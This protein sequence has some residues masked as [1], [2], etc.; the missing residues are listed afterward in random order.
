MPRFTSSLVFQKIP[1][2]DSHLHVPFD[3]APTAAVTSPAVHQASDVSQSFPKGTIAA[4]ALAGILAFVLIS[5]ALFYFFV[6][7]PRQR[8]LRRERREGRQRQ[9]QEVTERDGG[10]PA[11]RLGS[12]VVDIGPEPV[13]LHD[14]KNGS[15]NGQ[16]R[17]GSGL[18]RGWI[19]VEIDSKRRDSPRNTGFTKWKKDIESGFGMES[20]KGFGLAFRSPDS[21]S[22]R[23]GH[24]GSPSKNDPYEYHEHNGRESGTDED[25]DGGED[26]KSPGLPQLTSLEVP[27]KGDKKGKSRSTAAPAKPKA[28]TKSVRSTSSWTP[29]FTVDL[30]RFKSRSSSGSP[31]Y[32]HSRS[33]QTEPLA[34][35]SNAAATTDRPGG[36]ATP[37]SVPHSPHETSLASSLS[38]FSYFSF[39]SARSQAQQ[40]HRQGS[41]GGSSGLQAASL[42]APNSNSNSNS[43]PSKPPSP[44]APQ[45]VLKSSLRPSA[46]ADAKQGKSAKTAGHPAREGSTITS[47]TTSSLSPPNSVPRSA[48]SSIPLT[49]GSGSPKSEVSKIQIPEAL[50]E[51]SVLPAASLSRLDRPHESR[52]TTSPIHPYAAVAADVRGDEEGHGQSQG[53]YHHARAGSTGPLL[54]GQE[55]NEDENMRYPPYAPGIP[56]L[57]SVTN[58]PGDTAASAPGLSGDNL[59]PRT[60]TAGAIL[61]GLASGSSAEGTTGHGPLSPSSVAPI[62]TS[63]PA[64]AP[65][66]SPITTVGG[67]TIRRLPNP[68]VVIPTNAPP[69]PTVLSA[70]SPTATSAR[71]SVLRPPLPRPPTATSV[72]VTS[73]SGPSRANLPAVP[74]EPTTAVSESSRPVSGTD[75]TS[76]PGYLSLAESSPFSIPWRT[77]AE[78]QRISTA[79]TAAVPGPSSNSGATTVGLPP[80]QRYPPSAPVARTVSLSLP[81]R[82]V[83][84]QRLSSAEATTTPSAST[85]QQRPST[86]P[87]APPAS[88][89][90]ISPAKPHT[91]VK[92]SFRLTPLSPAALQKKSPN[93]RHKPR[94]SDE[95]AGADSSFLDFGGGRG[96]IRGSLGSGSATSGSASGFS[97]A[98]STASGSTAYER[99][100]EAAAANHPDRNRH[101]AFT[102]VREVPP[103]VPPL[104]AELLSATAPQLA[105]VSAS[106][107][108]ESDDASLFR[109]LK[110]R[111][112]ATTGS[113]SASGAPSESHPTPRGQ[114]TTQTELH[115]TPEPASSDSGYTTSRP[116][117]SISPPTIPSSNSSSANASQSSDLHVH[118][119]LSI[120]TVVSSNLGQHDT[121]GMSFAGSSRP[122]QSRGPGSA[123][124][125]FDNT[126][127]V[128]RPHRAS[129]STSTTNFTTISND[130]PGPSPTESLPISDIRFGRSSS[131]YGVDEGIN[132]DWGSG[133]SSNWFMMTGPGAGN[134]GGPVTSSTEGLAPAGIGARS[135]TSPSPVGGIRTQRPPLPFPSLGSSQS[136]VGSSSSSQIQYRH[137]SESSMN[138]PTRG[139]TAAT[140]GLTTPSYIVQRVLRPSGSGVL[141][142]GLATATQAGQTGSGI[143]VQQQ[144][145]PRTDR[146][147][148]Q[149]GR[150]RSSS[151]TF[152]ALLRGGNKDKEP[153]T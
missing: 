124:S 39:I 99:E 139:E 130:G 123:P 7:K 9:K 111:W 148:Q 46:N 64:S 145:E 28:K 52:R 20:L 98:A 131:D 42:H 146:P 88:S 153:Q 35:A 17:Q 96:H 70:V 121:L 149:H 43:Q 68:P 11:T 87:T 115:P 97:R 21:S 74:P 75:S 92:S 104:P 29:S 31:R 18:D 80:Y 77:L 34:G 4:L 48:V 37:G 144:Q 134:I 119:H 8:R 13:V 127:L 100:R 86:A 90:D 117:L 109:G 135:P 38:T 65:G 116:N 114:D 138:P 142:P 106:G 10:V 101:S 57:A 105:P 113:G 69:P 108:S 25:D 12:V 71:M 112:S 85:T 23:P 91:P 45:A 60:V 102:G 53:R 141:S 30:S 50:I 15:S 62:A 5:I 6:W 83:I 76:L 14:L 143:F 151:S 59:S 36:R 122:S 132:S 67:K 32:I 84:S 103:P 120:S 110:S 54:S 73:I 55:G 44:S 19:G 33:G 24:A 152:F 78:D 133:R 129:T 56:I 147:Q 140:G 128:P 136:Q 137:G 79:S 150:G 126:H 2:Y 81:A 118:P 27:Y 125:A 16:P 41:S 49:S 66:P 107:G 82:S 72:E 58:A 26:H 51:I 61:F 93:T 1:K 22:Q 3:S 40:Q 63:T 89:T 47:S 95:S 94:P